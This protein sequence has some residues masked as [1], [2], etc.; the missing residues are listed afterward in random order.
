MA[1]ASG[2]SRWTENSER[3][4]LLRQGSI[5]TV[6]SYATRTSPVIRGKWVLENILGAPPPPPPANVPVLEESPIRAELT[7]R[8]RLA[9]TATIPYAPTVTTRSTRSASRWRTSMPWGAGG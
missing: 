1:V 2:A 9:S 3:G 6:T 8:E 5:L 4:G 7:M